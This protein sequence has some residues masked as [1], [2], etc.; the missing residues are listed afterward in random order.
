MHTSPIPPAQSAQLIARA[1][2]NGG[3][4]VQ[5][6]DRSDYLVK[7]CKAAGADSLS[8]AQR[9]L[10]RLS[11]GRDGNVVIPRGQADDDDWVVYLLIQ[12]P[13]SSSLDLEAHNGG[14]GLRDFSGKADLR[15]QNGPISLHSTTGEVCADAHNGP[16]SVKGD[17]GN[18]YLRAQNGPISVALTGTQWQGGSLDAHGTNGPFEGEPVVAGRSKATSS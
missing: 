11:L 1:S 18:L 3:I 17:S 7:A 4:Y 10:G 5:G 9:V 13:R 12:A 14:I 15:V 16:I 8:E 6:A 2:T